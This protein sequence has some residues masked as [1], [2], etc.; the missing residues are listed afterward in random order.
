MNRLEQAI[1][2]IVDVFLEYAADDGKKRQLNKDELKKLL[3]REIQ[4]PELK[5][6]ISGD[7]IDAAM[8]TV[9]I[10]SDGEINFTEFSRCMSMLLKSYYNKKI[11]KK[12]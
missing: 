7:D 6:K 1:I 2:N 12:N 10:N 8:K 9:D 5:D 3:E 11:G 4:N